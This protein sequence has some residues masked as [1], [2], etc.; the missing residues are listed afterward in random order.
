[1]HEKYYADMPL[2]EVLNRLNQKT[3]EKNIAE[4]TARIYSALASSIDEQVGRVLQVLEKSGGSDNTIVVFTS[5]HS[6]MMSSHG[7]MG[8]NPIYD[9]FFFQ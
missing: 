7:C 8:K 9:E 2:E 5:N 1:M 3:S 4:I 6:E